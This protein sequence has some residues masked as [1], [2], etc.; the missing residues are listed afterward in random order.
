MFMV[1]LLSL[2]PWSFSCFGLAHHFYCSSWSG[3][4]ALHF[5]VYSMSVISTIM[6]LH[7]F[8][9]FFSLFG[10]SPC[11]GSFIWWNYFY[12]FMILIVITKTSVLLS[13]QQD[14]LF[15]EIACLMPNLTWCYLPGILLL[16]GESKNSI[17]FLFF[18]LHMCNP[19]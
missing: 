18:T 10:S 12:R 7:A 15:W 2:P 6:L 1:L 8:L 9:I 19:F 14:P 13:L 11:Q 17:S 16:N 5:Y 4:I 3:R